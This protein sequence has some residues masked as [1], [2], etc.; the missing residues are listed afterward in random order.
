MMD[1]KRILITGANGFIGSFIVEEALA[2][3]YEVW[4][5][6]RKSADLRYLQDKRIRF[7]D[8]P[9]HNSV[10]LMQ[11]IA[12]CKAE[13][14]GWH[15][16]VHN[17]GAT[18]AL[19]SYHF[20]KINSLYTRNLVDAL[21]GCDAVPQK[22]VLMSSLS[23]CGPFDENSSNP[24]PNN[25]QPKPNTKYGKSKLSAENYLKSQPRFPYIILRPT[26]VYGPRDKD[27]FLMIKTIR[28]GF[29]PAVGLR[30]QYL[31][32]IYV[33]DLARAALLAAA[34]PVTDKSY[35]LSDGNLYQASHFRLIVQ[36]ILGIKRVIS[37]KLPLV[38]VKVVSLLAQ[39]WGRITNKPATLNGDKYKIMKQRNWNCSV[40]EAG[41]DLG[42]TPRFDLQKGLEA[43]IRWYKEQNYL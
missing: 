32:F 10:L 18:K 35:Y 36:K 14:G 31:T 15:Y 30:P 2:S 24:I 22:F 38:F 6:V 12:R 3:G 40:A 26:G 43:S 11:E 29:D 17:L 8:L 1:S 23:V 34:S 19:K 27:Y 9:Y 7:V 5:A 41:R 16:V 13:F 42:F 25:Y 4:A 39:L 37:F 33:E 28:S 21:I 20:E